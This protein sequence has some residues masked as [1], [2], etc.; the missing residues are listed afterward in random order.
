M[1]S[2]YTRLWNAVSNNTIFDFIKLMLII[3]STFWY[4]N[5]NL[6]CFVF[7]VPV[8]IYCMVDGIQNIALFE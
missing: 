5:V 6:I 4:V 2:I 7:H 3:A 8:L 1:L